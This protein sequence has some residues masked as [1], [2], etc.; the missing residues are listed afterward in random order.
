MVTQN[1]FTGFAVA[2][3]YPEAQPP[4]M[5]NRRLRILVSL[6]GVLAAALPLVAQTSPRDTLEKA[7]A[8]VRDETFATGPLDRVIDFLTIEPNEKRVARDPERYYPSKVVFAP[9]V[10]YTPETNFGFGIGGSYLFKFP[11]SGDEER[12]R[13]SAIP[14]AFTYTLENQLLFYSGFEIFT[15][16]EAYVISGNARAQVFPRLFY[17]VGNSTPRTNEVVFESTELTFEPIFSKQVFVDKLFLGAG[18][19][20][21][22][23]SSTDFVLA[24]DA[25]NT[26]ADLAAYRNIRGAGGSRSVGAEVAALYDTRNSLLN[27]QH[28]SYFELT[29]GRYGTLLGGTSEYALTRA[30]A[31][32]FVQLKGNERWRDVLAVQ[33]IG[34][35]ASGDVPLVELAQLGSGEIMRGYYEGRYIDEAYVAAQG[36]YR[37]NIKNSPFGFVGFASAGTVAPSPGQFSL[38]KLRTAAGA[39][40]RFMV[41][42]VERL[43]LRADVA[44]TGEGDFNF[45]IQIGEAF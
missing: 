34:Y 21:R 28:G 10:I 14:I 3:P 17:G 38:G 15:P 29:Y 44:F 45:Y 42:P 2:S 41:D 9:Y 11:G 4:R 25:E 32:H 6:G 37:L 27:A 31:R 7:E 40:V 33:G 5:T 39:G 23:I 19:R 24:E 8:V 43:N 12:T 16:D 22:D 13:T 18:V 30:D 36:E 1:R 26:T 20:I 35:F